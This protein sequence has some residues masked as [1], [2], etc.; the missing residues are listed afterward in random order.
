L[1]VVIPAVFGWEGVDGG[2][3]SRVVRVKNIPSLCS[4]DKRRETAPALNRAGRNY[5]P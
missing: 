3:A 2:C 5:P 1:K 4:A